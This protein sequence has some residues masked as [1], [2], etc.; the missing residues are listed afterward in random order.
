MGKPKKT[1]R[2]KEQIVQEE[3]NKKEISRK[4]SLIVD[5]FY[6]ALIDATVSIAEAESL[7]SA[8]GSLVMEETLKTMKTLKFADIA[9]SLFKILCTDGEREDKIE[10][11]LATLHEENLFTAR[12]IIEGMNRAIG[13]MKYE[14]MKG[15]NLATLKT[16]WEGHLN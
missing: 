6:P 14:E 8:M 16:N 1:P 11:L 15:R 10:K 13:A 12:E 3:K 9:P 4:R 7:I 5:R 2:T